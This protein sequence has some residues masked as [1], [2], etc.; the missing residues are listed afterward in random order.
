M[1]WEVLFGVWYTT[2]SYGGEGRSQGCG[3]FVGRGSRMEKKMDNYTE[4]LG[5]FKGLFYNNRCILGLG[6][7]EK[8]MKFDM[9][10]GMV[11]RISRV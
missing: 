8:Q 11:Q 6:I 1:K 7:L 4:I 3:T 10:A 9:L 2:Y 5:P